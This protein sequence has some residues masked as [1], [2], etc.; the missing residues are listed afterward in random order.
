MKVIVFIDVQNDF[1]LTT[2]ALPYKYPEEPNHP[3]IVE[4]ANE[5]RKRGYAMFATLDTHYPT[6]HDRRTGY[7]YT[8]EGKNLPVEHCIEKTGGHRLIDGLANTFDAMEFVNIPRGHQCPKNSFGATDIGPD[9][10]YAMEDLGEHIEEIVICGYCTSICVVSNALLLRAE[11]P[12]TPITVIGDLCGDIDK[13]S[14]FAALKV[15]QNC[16]IFNKS[17]SAVL[18]PQ[19]AG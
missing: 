17:A 18:E 11:F 8:Y 2:G 1:V 10:R 16:M 9:I 12:D 15:M 5:C 14:H 4:F 6:N 7:L 13:E 19:D 3:K